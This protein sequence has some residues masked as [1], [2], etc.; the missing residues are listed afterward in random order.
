MFDTLIAI[1]KEAECP[2]FAVSIPGRSW[3]KA[4]AELLAD[5]EEWKRQMERDRRRFRGGWPSAR[6]S[7]C[8]WRGWREIRNACE[9]QMY[10]WLCS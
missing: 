7:D 5:L 9:Q 1:V 8:F 6:A 2:Y 10:L 4:R 3:V